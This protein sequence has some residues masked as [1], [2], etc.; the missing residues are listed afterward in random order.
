MSPF[1]IKTG[2]SPIK[3]TVKAISGD[4]IV[5]ESENEMQLMKTEKQSQITKLI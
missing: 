5:Y 2:N 3:I 4:T 1:I